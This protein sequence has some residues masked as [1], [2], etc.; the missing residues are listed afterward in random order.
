MTTAMPTDLAA[1]VREFQA[2]Q[3]TADLGGCLA[4]LTDDVTVDV[5][6]GHFTGK[7]G[8][9]EWLESTIFPIHTRT[10]ALEI[11][12]IVEDRVSAL[13]ALSDDNTRRLYLPPVRVQAEFVVREGKIRSLSARPTSESLAMVK[14]IQD[15]LAQERAEEAR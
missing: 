4:L 11:H 12:S 7:E 1:T 3:D 9:R 6:R 15:A 14:A 8:V 13:L 5:G 2:R 10:D